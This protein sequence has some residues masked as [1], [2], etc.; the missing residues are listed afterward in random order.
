MTSQRESLGA[1]SGTEFTASRAGG[2]PS[3]TSS[4]G[5]AVYSQSFAATAFSQLSA[6]GSGGRKRRELAFM[7]SRSTAQA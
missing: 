4:N 1:S 6:F 7:G 3:S 2:L 5:I